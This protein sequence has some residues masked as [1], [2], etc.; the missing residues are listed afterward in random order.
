MRTMT[1]EVLRDESG[2]ILILVLVLLVVGGLLLT[3]LLGLMS[4]GLASGQVYEKKAAELYAADAGVEEAIWYIRQGMTPDVGDEV[5]LSELIC[6]ELSSDGANYKT[7]EVM[8]FTKSEGVAGGTYKVTS[9]ATTPGQGSTTIEVWLDYMPEFWNNAI[10][11]PASIYLPENVVVDGDTAGT[12]TYPALQARGEVTG[13]EKAPWNPEAWPFNLDVAYW[14]NFYLNPPLPVISSTCTY[15]VDVA[16]EQSLGPWEFTGCDVEIKNTS[17]S[18]GIEGELQG[19]LYVSGD[20]K[21]L[22]IGGNHDFVLDLNYQT[23]FVEGEVSGQGHSQKKYALS[24]LSNV[25]LKG[26]GIIIAVG[27]ILFKPNF[28]AGSSDDFVFV[29]SLEGSIDS[30]PNALFYGSMAALDGVHIQG[31]Q[32]GQ[33]TGGE[34]VLIEYTAPPLD[35]LNFPTDPEGYHKVFVRTWNIG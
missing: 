3:P 25:T 11:T 5:L 14:R 30:Q 21:R 10:T 28:H 1:K 17:N 24:I 16:G 20:D 35:M 33:G 29:M 23:I 22:T 7:V 6:Q 15:V 32:G 9:K 2:K 12:V 18:A 19:T 13:Q 8:L 4:T 31:S 27:D 26:S 34:P